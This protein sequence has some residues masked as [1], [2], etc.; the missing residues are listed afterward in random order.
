MKRHLYLAVAAAVVGLFL[1]ALGGGTTPV[2]HA[3]E[4]TMDWDEVMCDGL[5]GPALCLGPGNVAGRQAGDGD[6]LIEVGE[7]PQAISRIWLDIA[8]L[9]GGQY[10]ESFFDIA[11]GLW[12]ADS[13]GNGIADGLIPAGARVAG[14][15]AP[16]PVGDQVGEISF[17]L[18]TNV[19]PAWLASN[20]INPAT[21]Q[22][23]YPSPAG[24]TVVDTFPMIASDITGAVLVSQYDLDGDGW[25]DTQAPPGTVGALP[26]TNYPG[27]VN[28][29]AP[30]PVFLAVL[31]LPSSSYIGR[32]FGIAWA[33]D[34]NGNHVMDG[35]DDTSDVNFVL[36]DLVSEGMG[37]LSFTLVNYPFMPSDVPSAANIAGQTMVTSP[38]YS[39]DP[40]RDFGLSTQADYNRDGFVD[41]GVGGL[42]NRV[43][44]VDPVT[45]AIGGYRYI[46]L[47]S[48]NEDW[49]GDTIAQAY[50]N[51][52][53]VANPAQT[54]ADG[55]T[56]GAACDPNDASNPGPYGYVPGSF[57]V[58][59]DP[60]ADNWLNRADNCPLVKNVSQQD[61]DGDGVGDACDPA[62]GIPGSGGG[63][64]AGFIDRDNICFDVFAVN[65][66][67]PALDPGA[68]ACGGP[69]PIGRCCVGTDLVPAPNI[70]VGWPLK[71]SNDNGAADFLDLPPVY[72]PITN[73]DTYDTDDTDMDWE[74]DACE[75]KL[76]TDPLNA[77]SNSFN[78]TRMRDC[79]NGGAPD[80]LEALVTKAHGFPFDAD[81][82]SAA[83]DPAVM[84][85][86]DGGGA[87][88]TVE[89]IA[90]AACIPLTG[91][92]CNPANPADDVALTSDADGDGIPTWKELLGS[93]NPANP[94]SDGDGV[95]DGAEVL[96]AGVKGHSLPLKEGSRCISMLDGA[97]GSLP[98]KVGG[99]D[100]VAVKAVWNTAHPL[101]TL[102]GSPETQAQR[103]ASG[104]KVAAG[105]IVA[106]KAV[107]NTQPAGCE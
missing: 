63:Y 67:E 78:F 20:N 4:S 68:A 59:Q 31:G 64:A 1:W 46:I 60:D 51:C 73:V 43:V 65:A 61:S 10:N 74:A 104:A 48:T 29:P 77:A 42:V 55:D 83:D 14:A 90:A 85:D 95:P 35:P 82:F 87:P 71:D 70:A 69:S 13:D 22:P 100:I 24:L 80:Y 52:A 81:M 84:T 15:P 79:D 26:P 56:I 91:N 75:G 96:A 39:S 66:P 38:P 76:G 19:N 54:D 8:G 30:I 28:T 53:M 21:G 62:P 93:T 89:L 11:S 27:S 7:N 98:F 18:G 97:A 40:V 106:V 107:W 33:V 12:E 36:F 3:D 32:S 25:P 44:A 37:Y 99:G 102:D 17:S 92:P 105:D 41:G 6:T 34:A 16:V 45:H 47:K 49:D 88:D 94:D 103:I 58:G 86:S 72:P 101:A 23:P 2:A 57:S 9:G 50:D 5:V